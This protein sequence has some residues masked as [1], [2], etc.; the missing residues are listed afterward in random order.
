MSRSH[1][2]AAKHRHEQEWKNMTEAQYVP[3]ENTCDAHP[4]GSDFYRA[5]LKDDL[6]KV[7]SLLDQDGSLVN[8]QDNLG[9]TVLHWLARSPGHRETIELL[10][11]RGAP[12]TTR[13]R[14]GNT[15]LHLAAMAPNRE[16]ILLFLEN[17]ADITATTIDGMTP[18]HMSVLSGIP[19]IAEIMKTRGGSPD[20]QNSLGMKPRDIAKA[21]GLK[22]TEKSLREKNR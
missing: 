14:L 13:D 9:M 12:L 5:A 15:P 8:L 17:G 19:E 16:A 18:L 21:F 22:D 2:W 1:D 10:L 7:T 20:A 3:F 6:E 11:S 4:L